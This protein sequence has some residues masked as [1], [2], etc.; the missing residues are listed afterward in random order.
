[1]FQIVYE[2]PLNPML[3]QNM[4]VTLKRDFRRTS[5]SNIPRKK[6][7]FQQDHFTDL[8]ASTLDGHVQRDHRILGYSIALTPRRLIDTL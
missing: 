8:C 3:K 4:I 5:G 6:N 2:S 1:M 7:P